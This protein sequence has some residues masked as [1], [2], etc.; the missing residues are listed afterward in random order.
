LERTIITNPLDRPASSEEVF[1]TL[2][3]EGRA[4]PFI[5]LADTMHG[6]LQ[7]GAD[8]RPRLAAIVQADAE[9]LAIGV[10]RVI[11]ASEVIVHPLPAAAGRLTTLA[12][13]VFDAQGNPPAPGLE[14]SARQRSE[15]HSRR[16][17]PA[18]F[19]V[20]TNLR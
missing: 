15:V 6:G 3:F 8:S 19:R 11:H 17:Y 5:R 2:I 12:G 14:Q 20:G 18:R 9:L 1:S 7:N 16:S 4:T 13:A 10:D